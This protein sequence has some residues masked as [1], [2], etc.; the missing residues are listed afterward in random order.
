MTPDS[1]S[2]S[3][4]TL[5]TVE[6]TVGVLTALRD[7]DGATVSELADRLDLSR[8]GVYKHLATLAECDLVV[9]RGDTYHLA[10][11]LL[12]LGQYVRHGDPLYRS[13][14]T[15]VEVLAAETGGFVH[16]TAEEYGRGIHVRTASGEHGVG[17]T[18]HDAG[19][20]R[21]DYLHCTATGKAILATYSRERVD[22]ILDEHGLPEKTDDTITSRARLHETLETIR[23]RGYAVNDEEELAGLRAVGAPI[24]PTDSDVLGAISVSGPV[25]RL[26]GETFAETLP[27]SVIEVANVIEVTVETDVSE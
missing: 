25:S 14:E 1:T 19:L 18:Y 17:I 21:P 23:E 13:S 15:V 24:T 27:M 9:Q 22:A 7:C 3:P 26:S 20:E 5:S 6:T 11:H 16:L 8:P 10:L 2:E 12:P 4:R